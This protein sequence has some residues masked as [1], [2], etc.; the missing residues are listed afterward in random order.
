MS[1]NDVV[2]SLRNRLGVGRDGG[3]FIGRL[4]PVT[5]FTTAI[6]RVGYAI[7][8]GIAFFPIEK[9]I[10]GV[11]W[12]SG[13]HHIG[14]AGLG[15]NDRAPAKVGSLMA[16]IDEEPAAFHKVANQLRGAAAAAARI[17]LRGV[18]VA[19]VQ[20]QAYAALIGGRSGFNAALGGRRSIQPNGTGL[21][22]Q[23]YHYG[24][25]WASGSVC[26]QFSGV[27]LHASAGSPISNSATALSVRFIR[28]A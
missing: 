21:F 13:I 16:G 4:I 28:Y 26:A 6:K 2:R 24:Y 1:T 17:Q 20:L 27:S 3:E 11:T 14:R 15:M 7:Q 8:S 19:G 23:Q 12:Q 10:T 18:G 25:Y 9:R 5:L 22:E